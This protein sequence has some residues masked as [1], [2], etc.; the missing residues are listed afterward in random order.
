M[1]QNKRLYLSYLLDKNTPTYGNRNQFIC[2]KKSD[3][4]KG[5]VANDSSINTTVHIG[6]HI[7]MP[8]HFFENGQTIA[9]FDINYFSSDKVLY[10]DFIPKDLIIKDD[11]IAL[12]EKITNKE[13]YEFLIIKTGICNKRDQEEFWKSNYGFDPSLAKY[14]RSHFPQIRIIGFDSISV[15]SFENRMLGRE[16]H[17]AFLDP[18]NPILILEDM[19]LTALSQ[20]SKIEKMDIVPLRIAKCDGLPC[21]IIAEVK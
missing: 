21:T 3:I 6:T 8:Y 2:E 5:D 11:L 7:D 16:A 4:A 19:D 13:V 14:I 9:Y 15:S 12:L 1:N 20:M 10:L 17:R 18:S